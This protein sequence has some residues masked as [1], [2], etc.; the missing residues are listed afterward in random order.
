MVEF[1]EPEFPFLNYGDGNMAQLRQKYEMQNEDGVVGWLMVINPSRAIIADYNL[2]SDDFDEFGFVKRWYPKTVVRILRD[3]PVMGRVLIK[4]DFDGHD[5]SL[6]REVA[7]FSEGI[8]S[9]EKIINALKASNARYAK[10][11]KQSLSQLREYWMENASLLEAARKKTAGPEEEEF[12]PE[13]PGEG[14]TY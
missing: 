13:A 8:Q 3:D 11:L 10:E 4:T 9:R 5:T 14:P 1:R 6:S 7:E 2:R 12:G